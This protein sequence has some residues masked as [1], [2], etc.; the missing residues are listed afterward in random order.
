VIDTPNPEDPPP[1]GAPEP[2][3]GLNYFNYFTEVEDAFQTARGTGLFLLSPLDWALIE[4][5]KNAGVPLE[6]VLRGIQAAFEKWRAR[7]IRGRQVNSLAY[8]AQA[9]IEEAEA[10][11]GNAPPQAQPAR[12]APFTREQLET[13]LKAAAQATQA[14]GHADIA[15]ALAG[16]NAAG[17]YERLEELEQRLTALEEKF[18]AKVRA[19][20]PDEELFTA[21]REMDAELRPYR[22][23]FSA[24]QLARLERQFLDRWIFQRLGVPRFSI[25][26]VS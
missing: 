17:C 10:M 25:F 9:V 5:W 6:A 24:D 12:Q 22:S 16:L 13:H 1:E 8:C 2:W 4:T 7:K 19:A 14:A 23:K 3:D 20:L 26:Y 21:R 18:L 11:A 15:E